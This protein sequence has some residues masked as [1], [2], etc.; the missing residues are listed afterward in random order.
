MKA[1]G[2][3]P[4]FPTTPLAGLFADRELLD[5]QKHFSGH[6]ERLTHTAPWYPG[7]TAKVA[8]ARVLA[9]RTSLVPGSIPLGKGF[10]V[11][12]LLWLLP[13]SYGRI[14][15][16]LPMSWRRKHTLRYYNLLKVTRHDKG[17]T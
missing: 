13:C 2:S 8:R 14:C 7:K 3:S 1:P 11:Y 6:M 9:G 12:D 4:S 17:N 10:V 15:I 16:V 5:P